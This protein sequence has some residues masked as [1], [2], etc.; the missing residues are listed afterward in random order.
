MSKTILKVEGLTASYGNRNILNNVAFSLEEGKLTAL[1][2]VNGV[3]KTMLMKCLAQRLPHAGSC[4]L[5]TQ[6]LEQL[7]VRELAKRISY[8]PQ[9]SG[10][11]ISLPVLDVVLMGYNPWL[12]LLQY[13]S[14]QQKQQALKA[15]ETV[16]LSEVAEQ[17][18]QT[19]SEGQKQ[20]VYL[21]RTLIE[22][23]KL[24]LLDEPDSALDF[25][26]RHQILQQLR[27]L[28]EEEQKAALLCLHDPQLALQ[29]C[30]KLLL[31]KDGIVFAELDVEHD[32]VESIETALRQ[33]YGSVLLLEHRSK[34][35]K[36]QLLLLWE[37]ES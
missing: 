35:G 8:I 16:G 19:L 15:L 18:Y 21:A 10:L 37:D 11:R 23:S 1:L 24:L 26:N 4:W 2:G 32:A 3:G 20:L 7:S 28:V 9:R 30:Q 12:A 33:L 6:C 5:E 36:R 27:T 34:Q 31:L 29:F 22:Q 14:Q 17:D 13:P 25:Q